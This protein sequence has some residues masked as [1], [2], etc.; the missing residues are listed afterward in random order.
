[1]SNEKPIIRETGEICA[2]CGAPIAE[3]V[4]QPARYC[5]CEP[6]SDRIEALLA[7]RDA[8]AEALRGLMWRFDES[9]EDDH[10][11]GETAPDILAARAALAEIEAE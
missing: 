8:L 7:Q 4:N 5:G 11:P 1:M 10:E 6:P 2:E 9:D 3:V